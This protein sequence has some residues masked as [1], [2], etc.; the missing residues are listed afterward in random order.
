LEWNGRTFAPVHS[1]VIRRHDVQ[2]NQK[3]TMQY[4]KSLKPDQQQEFYGSI[5]KLYY[6]GNAEAAM[7]F[8]KEANGENYDSAHT[9]FVHQLKTR[10]FYDDVRAINHGL[11]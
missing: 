1:K 9:E 10:P 5:I 3:A 7:R 2:D 6:S 11:L 8:M 4:L